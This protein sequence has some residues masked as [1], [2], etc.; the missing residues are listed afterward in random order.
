MWETS[1]L[2]Q[3]SEHICVSEFSGNQLLA[4]TVP[5]YES[6]SELLNNSVFSAAQLTKFNY[7]SLK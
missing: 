5:L 4:M 1:F 6:Y 2:S 3:F 7:V